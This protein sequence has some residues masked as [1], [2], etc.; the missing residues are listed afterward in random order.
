LKVSR[1]VLLF[2]VCCLVPGLWSSESRAG[3]WLQRGMDMLRGEPETTR[4][5]SSLTEQDIALGLREALR[6]GSENVV[7]H[8]GREGGYYL[9]PRAH[10]PL[11]EGLQKVQQIM[12]RAGLGRTLDDLELRLNRAA[13]LATP[14]A[15]EMFMSAVSEMTMEDVRGIL[16]GPNDAATRYFQDQMSGPLSREFTPIVSESLAEAGAVRVYDQLM[17][18]YRKLPFVPDAQADL[19]RHVVDL[20]IEAIFGYLA[21]EEAA[22]RNNPGKQTTDIL[23]RVF[24]R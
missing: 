21:L 9:D 23:R 11:P 14:R 24:G 16:N 8:L 10:I 7:N 4:Q 2:A 3:D 17:S 22:I 19:S 6:V 20:S 18:D 5:E 13:E 1:F 15:R 12:N